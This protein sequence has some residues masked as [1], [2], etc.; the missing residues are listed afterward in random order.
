MELKSALGKLAMAAR[1]SSPKE[2]RGE[3]LD[4]TPGCAFGAL[5]EQQLRQ[6][7]LELAEV[8]GRLNGLIFLVVS[9]VVV[10]VVVK[11]VK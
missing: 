11:L 6:I 10:E 9:A 7:D 5:V 4:L 2:G 3:K 1:S 8:K